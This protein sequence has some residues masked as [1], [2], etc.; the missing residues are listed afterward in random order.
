LNIYNSPTDTVTP[1]QIQDAVSYIKEMASAPVGRREGQEHQD[2]VAHAQ[3]L[4]DEEISPVDLPEAPK[5]KAEPY[6]GQ[7]AGRRQ[8]LFRAEPLTALEAP[9]AP[10]NP[11]GEKYST[12]AGKDV[13]ISVPIENGKTAKLTMDAQTVLNDIDAR[14]EALETVRKCLL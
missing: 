3:R 9:A 1:Q 12:L 11:Y 6:V 5:P 13:T 4:L 8:S 14:L 2:V 7:V 10:V